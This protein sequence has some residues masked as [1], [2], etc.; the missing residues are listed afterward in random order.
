MEMREIS[1]NL[2]PYFSFTDFWI[3]AMYLLTFFIPYCHVLSSL[4]YSDYQFTIK[5]KMPFS[6]DITLKFKRFWQITHL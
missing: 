1:E 3:S 4:V 2:D 5:N 6:Q